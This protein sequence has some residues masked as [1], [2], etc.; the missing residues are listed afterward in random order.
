V[1]VGEMLDRY[2]GLVDV[3]VTAPPPLGEAIAHVDQ[4]A[5]VG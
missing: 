1:L 4:V 2:L 5:S 3:A